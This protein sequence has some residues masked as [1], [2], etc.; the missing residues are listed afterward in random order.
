MNR[1]HWKPAL[2]TVIVLVVAT[3]G[4][5]LI[6]GNTGS[7]H[8]AEVP[9][10]DEQVLRAAE[11]PRVEDAFQPGDAAT[12]RVTPRIASVP[13]V[14]DSSTNVAERRQLLETIGVL[15][16]AHCYQTYFNIGLIADGKARGTYTEKD[17]SKLLD[18]VL[19][20][21]D[22]VDRRLT[23]LSKIDLEKADR[24]SLER[25]RDLSDLLHQQGKALEIF[26]DSGKD[27][28]AAK[29]E[30]VRKDSWAAISK[31]MGIGR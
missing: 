8:T 23:V 15:T 28:D 24:D 6:R 3:A 16:A 4:G 26:W 5:L 22:S 30:D 17:A 9:T 25:M 13:K 29:Y 11:T 1:A 18:T 31:L 27:D 12:A 21:L 20:L 14:G 10:A 19:S 2:L 7:G